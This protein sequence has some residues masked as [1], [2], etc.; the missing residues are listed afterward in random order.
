MLILLGGHVEGHGCIFCR[1]TK[2]HIHTP[3]D[4]CSVRVE[5]GLC[6]YIIYSQRHCGLA[7]ACHTFSHFYVMSMMEKMSYPRWM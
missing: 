1:V 4:A 3:S 2:L 6:V 5:V 7:N